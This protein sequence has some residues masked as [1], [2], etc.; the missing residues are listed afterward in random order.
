MVVFSV[1]IGHPVRPDPRRD[2]NATWTFK[3]VI[4]CR[5]SF[6]MFFH[7]DDGYLSGWFKCTIRLNHFNILPGPLLH[8]DRTLVDSPAESTRLFLRH[9][10]WEIFQ[11][12]TCYM[13]TRSFGPVDTAALSSAK[14]RVPTSL[15]KLSLP[16]M[17]R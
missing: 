17:S 14:K 2:L 3:R 9:F 6:A 7:R 1:M 5:V 13:Q 12:M 15:I 8:S 16:P 4:R 11:K 10:I